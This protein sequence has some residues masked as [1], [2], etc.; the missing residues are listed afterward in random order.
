MRDNQR[1]KVYNWEEP[2]FAEV[3]NPSD[4]MSSEECL[5]FANE[6][7]KL[8]GSLKWH[9]NLSI[10]DNS[11]SWAEWDFYHETLVLPLWARNKTVICHEVSHIIVGEQI[12]GWHGAK[13]VM[14]YIKL[15]DYFNLADK[16]NL[17]HEAKLY[18]VKVANENEVP[19]IRVKKCKRLRG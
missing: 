6:C 14:M 5:K 16:Q 18:S 15:L 13:F 11:K 3:D 1:S 2:Y 7:L 8:T 10:K 17:L 4:P 12:D 19:K 9:P